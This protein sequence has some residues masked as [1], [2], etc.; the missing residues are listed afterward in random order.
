VLRVPGKR[1]RHAMAQKQ[2]PVNRNWFL[3][4]EWR[5]GATEAETHCDAALAKKRFIREFRGTR[6]GS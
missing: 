5:V 3:S 2:A 4:G 1:L 6:R